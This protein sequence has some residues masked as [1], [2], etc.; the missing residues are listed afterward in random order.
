MPNIITDGDLSVEPM[1]LTPDKIKLIWQRLQRHKTLFSD[2]TRGDVGVFVRS[3]TDQG[4][5][6]FEVREHGVIVGLVWF[7][8]MSQVTECTAHLVFLDRKP[9]SKIGVCKQIIKWM[10]DNYPLQRI[11]VTPPVIYHGTV[12][13][14]KTLGFTREG[15]KR[16][17]VLLGGKWNDVLIY[18]I[19]R[20]E[21]VE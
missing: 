15:C 19:T 16:R 11:T 10:F 12:R 20:E 3:L 6:W 1:V 8:N 17:A 18:G 7:E 13:L 21:V 4:S 9:A 5:L 14:L 2:L